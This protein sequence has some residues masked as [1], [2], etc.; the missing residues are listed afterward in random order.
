MSV[1]GSCWKTWYSVSVNKL[2][3]S[4]TKWTKACHKRL[5]RL[6]SYIHH[7]SEYR[8][9]CYVEN[10]AQESIFELFQDSDFAGD[11]GVLYNFGSHTFCAVK[12]D[13][14]ETDFSFTQFYWSWNHFSRCRF[15]LG[16]YSRSHTLWDLVIEVFQSERNETGGPEREPRGN[17][18]Q[19]SSQTCITPS[20]SSTPTSFQQTLITLHPIQRILIPVLCC[21]SLRTMKSW[22]RRISKV[23]VAQWDMFHGP[24]ELLLIGCSIGL[25]WTPIIQIRYIDTIHQLADMLAK[26]NFTRDEWNNLLRLFNI[27]HTLAK[28]IQNQK[29]EARVVSKSRPA[30]MDMSLF[31][32][33]KFFL[34][35]EC[36]CIQKAGDAD[37]FGETRQQDECWTKLIRRRV[38]ISSPTQGCIP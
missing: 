20:Q 34:R 25:V 19:L 4:I 18:R 5:S 36:D 24:T 21:M 28:R 35:I 32:C 27:S 17:R 38:D 7:T 37:S 10:T 31:F 2:A 23:E 33:H 3:R 22:S 1:F 13:V 16:R 29:E 8:Q 15:T 30:V 14:Q 11:L 9:H 26:G 6:I 12:L